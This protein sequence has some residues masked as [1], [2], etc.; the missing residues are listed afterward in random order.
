MPKYLFRVM[1]A[2]KTFL[3]DEEPQ[4][5]PDLESAK[6]EAMEGAREILSAAALAGKAANF[7]T[8]IEVQDEAGKSLFTVRCGRVV[9]ADTQG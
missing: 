3:G 6:L 1:E 5:F 7:D 9:E 8:K 4:E 2:G